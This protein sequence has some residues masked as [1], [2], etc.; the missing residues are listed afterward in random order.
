[1]C[2]FWGFVILFSFLL[3]HVFPDSY[4]VHC[5]CDSL[6]PWQQITSK[7]WNTWEWCMTWAASGH[8][9]RLQQ[10]QQKLIV[11]KCEWTLLV[12]FCFS[13]SENVGFSHMNLTHTLKDVFL[14]LCS[15]VAVVTSISWTGFFFMAHTEQVPAESLCTEV[16][17]EVASDELKVLNTS[18]V[19]YLSVFR[20]LKI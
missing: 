9:T 16:F 1:M 6:N 3:H 18:S 19:L 20:S 17:L 14:Y 15:P 5:M 13:D 2:F 12:Q 10:Q 8:P 11:L 4:T 7:C